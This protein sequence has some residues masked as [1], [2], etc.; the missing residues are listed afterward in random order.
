MISLDVCFGV[1]GALFDFIDD[2][3]SLVELLF[4]R[5]DVIDLLLPLHVP[6]VEILLVCQSSRSL[7]LRWLSLFD[8]VLPHRLGLRRRCSGFCCFWLLGLSLLSLLTDSSHTHLVK[9]FG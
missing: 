7:G 2:P 4:E 1:E 6:P 5:T 3:L 9:L 8:K